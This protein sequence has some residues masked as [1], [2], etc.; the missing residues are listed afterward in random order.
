MMVEIIDKIFLFYVIML[1]IRVFSSF[2]P[3]YRDHEVL[4]FIAF[5]T[6]PYLNIFRKIIPPAGMIDFSPMIAFLFLS[7]LEL[8]LKSLFS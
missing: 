8:F 2:F 3:E 1:F 4:R 6:D 5:C 7:V